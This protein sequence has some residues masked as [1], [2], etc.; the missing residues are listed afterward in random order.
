MAVSADAIIVAAMA[1]NAAASTEVVRRLV[2]K[3]RRRKESDQQRRDV[4]VE[5]E[6]IVADQA[7]D[8]STVTDIINILNKTDD[9]VNDAVI[10]LGNHVLI[11]DS[12]TGKP[13]VVVRE[14]SPDQR[15]KISNRQAPMN[16]AA[17]FHA[18]LDDTRQPESSS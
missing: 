3:V 7:D 1:V 6:R 10:V 15:E 11:K 2:S 18:W 4:E 9:P 14:I 8:D 13:K 5:I 17:L 12:A 16:D